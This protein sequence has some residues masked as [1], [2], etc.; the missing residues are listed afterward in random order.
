MTT[1]PWYDWK[2]TAKKAAAL[3]LLIGAGIL[4]EALGSEAAAS[5][6]VPDTVAGRAV[7]IAGLAAL[8]RAANNYRKQH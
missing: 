5:A 6:F 1:N 8:G 4:G 2:I 3:A 7:I